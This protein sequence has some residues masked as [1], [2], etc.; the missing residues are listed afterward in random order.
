M[1]RR[2]LDP[3]RTE[4]DTAPGALP[5]PRPPS[6]PQ[7]LR[8]SHEDRDEVVEQLRIAAGD[9]RLT[10]E[11]LDERLEAALNA[12]TYGELAVLLQD[13]PAVAPTAAPV[14]AGATGPVGL[15]GEPARE[16][17]QLEAHRSNLARRGPWMV[18]RRLEV[19]TRG[20]NAVVDFSE[21]V[22]SH[23]VLDLVLTMKSSNLRLVVP[24]GVVVTVDDLVVHSSNV[25]DRVH[26]VPGTPVT[27]LIRVSGEA[28]SS[29]VL[30]RSPQRGFLARLRERRA[31]R[32]ARNA[33]QITA[34]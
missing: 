32:S 6:G 21:A 5:V 31:A 22:I 17:L 1:S 3:D 27:L 7:A 34:A 11:E 29:N 18:P 14:L 12:R 10:A 13:L 8:A 24:T 20:A 33:G 15:T 25:R 28:R 9:G 16:V 26:H 19:D 30:V 23:P 2:D 4:P